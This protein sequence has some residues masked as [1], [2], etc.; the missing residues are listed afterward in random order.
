MEISSNKLLN[1][2]HNNLYEDLQHITK[3]IIPNE[4]LNSVQKKEQEQQIT[5]AF[6]NIIQYMIISI[7]NSLTNNI[8]YK[9]KSNL[10]K[11]VSESLQDKHINESIDVKDSNNIKD[12]NENI[13][14]E[15]EA[16]SK[17]LNVHPRLKETIF[18]R[19]LKLLDKYESVTNYTLQNK[20][21]LINFFIYL[22]LV[23]YMPFQEIKDF[24]KTMIIEVY[25][26]IQFDTKL[27]DLLRK[28]MIEKQ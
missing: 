4:F 8:T 22:Q 19:Y 17:S 16:E 27:K 15:I 2:I 5:E 7:T 1:D 23:I 25:T 6:E 14:E 26:P 18:N 24:I 3:T 28:K 20:E 10:Y 11:N 21:Q 13:F 9:T 12:L